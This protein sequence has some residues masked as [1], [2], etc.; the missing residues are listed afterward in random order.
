[1]SEKALQGSGKRLFQAK[2]TASAKVLRQKPA[3]LPVQRGVE[4]SE[5]ERSERER[6]GTDQ[7]L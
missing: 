7:I 1:M 2:A 3:V 4:Q 6:Q 5:G